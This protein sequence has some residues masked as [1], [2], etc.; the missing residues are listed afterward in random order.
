MTKIVIQDKSLVE[1][2]TLWQVNSPLDVEV[3]VN[4]SLQLA[5]RKFGRVETLRQQHK[6]RTMRAASLGPSKCK[7]NSQH[8]GGYSG[9][10]T[11]DW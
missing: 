10:E 11:F 8:C 7:W 6:L 4:A 9:W 5:T 3:L 1:R 2:R